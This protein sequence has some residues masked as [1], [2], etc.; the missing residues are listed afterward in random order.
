MSKRKLNLLVRSYIEGMSAILKER[1]EE[2]IICQD[3][4]DTLTARLTRRETRNP[5]CSPDCW[6]NRGWRSKGLYWPK[7]LPYQPRKRTTVE[8]SRPGFK[9]ATR[10][11]LN[12]AK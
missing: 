10:L 4:M 12:G 5:D 8:A 6:P 3:W 1:L 2:G 11:P 7:D 9:P